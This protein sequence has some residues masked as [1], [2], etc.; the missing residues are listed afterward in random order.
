MDVKYR[1]H[2]KLLQFN[3]HEKED[4][5]LTSFPQLILIHPVYLK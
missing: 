2:P 1:V 4:Y 5:L 3:A